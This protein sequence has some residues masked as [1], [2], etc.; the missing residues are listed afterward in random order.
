MYKNLTQ[1][2]N[3][4]DVYSRFKQPYPVNIAVESNIPLFPFFGTILAHFT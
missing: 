1:K 3:S 2:S 4:L